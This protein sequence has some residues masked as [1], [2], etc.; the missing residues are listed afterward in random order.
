M[1]V[2]VV[3]CSDDYWAV[4]S[5]RDLCASVCASVEWLI[6]VWYVWY[7]GGSYCLDC[8]DSAVYYLD[9]AG[10]WV[11]EDEVGVPDVPVEAGA[12]G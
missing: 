11:D 9:Y 12:S 2:V 7:V 5:S 8:S 1:V 6:G 4:D 10:G 3:G